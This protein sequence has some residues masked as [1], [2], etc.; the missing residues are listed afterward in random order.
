MP[1]PGKN[2]SPL[3]GLL[4]IEA[5]REM[6]GLFAG[7]PSWPAL[8]RSFQY[9]PEY[10]TIVQY[11]LKAI[12]IGHTSHSYSRRHTFTKLLISLVYRIHTLRSGCE[13]IRL[14]PKCWKISAETKRAHCATRRNRREIVGDDED[15]LHSVTTHFPIEATFACMPSATWRTRV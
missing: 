13:H 3:N 6:P 10:V 2:P 11:L 1:N 15:S 5:A 9:S 12:G 7:S 4:P 14:P 8:T